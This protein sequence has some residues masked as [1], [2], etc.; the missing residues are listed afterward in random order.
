MKQAWR[1]N[2]DAPAPRDVVTTK[3]GQLIVKLKTKIQSERLKDVLT[4]AG[5][6]KDKIKVVV[7]RGRLERFLIL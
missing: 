6:L 4:E 7:P 3:A 5:V 1:S 2:S